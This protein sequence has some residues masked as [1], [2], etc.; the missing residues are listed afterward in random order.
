MFC[1]KCGTETPDDSQFCRK[2]GKTLGPVSTG[3]GTAA[4]PAP[5]SAPIPAPSTEARRMVNG[6]AIFGVLVA[7]FFAWYIV[8]AII[9]TQNTNQAIATIVHAP[10]TLK[11]EVQNLPANSW[12]AVSLNLPYSG[13]VN[14]SLEVVRGNPVDVF[15]VNANQLETIKKEDWHNVQVVGDFNALKAKLYRRDVQ[16]TQGGYYLVLRDTSLGILSASASDISVKVELN[17]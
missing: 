17:P 13:A 4:V 1:T 14:V 10:I 3:R 12:R 11:N 7:L 5:T 2:C 9:G 15:L 8:R 6:T 16:L